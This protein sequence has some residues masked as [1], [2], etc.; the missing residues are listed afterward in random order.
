MTIRNLQIYTQSLWDWGILKGCFGSTHIEPTDVDG[1]IER[2]GKFLLLEAKSPGKF[3]PKGQQIMFDNLL[4]TGIFTVLVI[5]GQPNKPEQ[6]QVWGQLP[7]P[8]SL[9]T[10]RQEIS[11]WYQDTEAARFH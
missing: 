4:K 2:R 10:L 7:R 8:A 9:D 1:L 3:I 11:K 5:W 6:M